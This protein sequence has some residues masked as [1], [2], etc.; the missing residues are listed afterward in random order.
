LKKHIIHLFTIFVCGSCLA[1]ET[2]ERS[3]KLT[4]DVTERFQVLKT[5]DTV[6]NGTYAAYYN[7]K[8]IAAGRYDNN[9]K[10]STWTY[11]DA[12]GVVC[13]RFNYEKQALVYEAP[14]DSVSAVRYL[15]DDSLK[16]SP[17]FTRPV[18]IGGRFYGYLNYINLVK[19]PPDYVG[20]SNERDRVA[21]E[22]LISP[23]GRL[24]EFKLRIGSAYMPYSEGDH[25]L[26]LNT[27]L[28][29]EE[30]KI[31]VPASLNG[32]PIAVRMLIPCE[33]Y[34]GDRIRLK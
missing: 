3:R 17:V 4:P 27:K 21:L 5:N 26:T 7:K 34:R 19:L 15:V 18:R 30:D 10:V 28:L 14:P 11:F 16:N 24:A 8:L 22:L 29:A 23:G 2:V 1:Q 9:K 25:L 20:L 33:F 31:F 13:Q 6:M 12:K 32:D